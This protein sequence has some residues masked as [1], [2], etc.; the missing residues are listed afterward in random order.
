[1]TN[2]TNFVTFTATHVV[3]ARKRVRVSYCRGH[4]PAGVR[5]AFAVENN[6]D[7]TTDYFEA[8]CVRLVPGHPHY[9]AVAAVAPY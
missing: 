7:M 5:A 2:V 9:E 8:D 6:S 3:I 1:M 4:F